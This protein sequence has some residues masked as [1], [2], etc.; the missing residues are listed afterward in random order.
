MCLC[1]FVF[2]LTFI[3]CGHVT[4]VPVCS[5]GPSDHLVVLT[6]CNVIHQEPDKY[7]TLSHDHIIQTQVR[8]VGFFFKGQKKKLE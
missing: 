4:M 8:F 7:G 6:L 3:F 2:D 5:S 1:I